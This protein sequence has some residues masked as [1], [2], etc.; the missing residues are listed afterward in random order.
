[1]QEI[2]FGILKHNIES[3]NDVNSLAKEYQSGFYQQQ[4]DDVVWCKSH[5]NTFYPICYRSILKLLYFHI[6]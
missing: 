4:Y 6:L 5:G 1:M 2:F 3:T